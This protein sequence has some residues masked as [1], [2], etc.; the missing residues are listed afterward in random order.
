MYLSSE[1]L[2]DRQ[3]VPKWQVGQL[4]NAASPRN[5][6][7][8]PNPT[9]PHG[10]NEAAAIHQAASRFAF[11][12]EEEI[13][14]HVHPDELDLFYERR[15]KPLKARIDARYMC[16]ATFWSDMRV[17]AAT[18]VACVA[19]D[20]IAAAN[21]SAASTPLVMSKELLASEAFPAD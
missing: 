10:K 4:R 12:R 11:R 19:P 1:P 18:F 7:A 2:T 5:H 3:H 15:I 16:R 6:L 13:L 9:E 20:R 21:I 17:I 8:E 14:S